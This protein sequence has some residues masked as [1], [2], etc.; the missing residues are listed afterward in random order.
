MWC[1]GI[2]L[3]LLWTA[4]ELLRD[5][6]M[7]RKG[8]IKGDIYSFAIILQEV[9]ARGPPYCTSELSAEGRQ[10]LQSIFKALC[11]A[12]KKIWPSPP[13]NQA[14]M[15]SSHDLSQWQKSVFNKMFIINIKMC[16]SHHSLGACLIPPFTGIRVLGA[17]QEASG[18]CSTSNSLSKLRLFITV[19]GENWGQSSP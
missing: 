7:C 18:L 13:I 9:V 8:T 2:F 6:D 19:W 5:P 17:P 3:E 1:S 12:L 4:P 14:I 11:R 15:Y 16:S 10:L